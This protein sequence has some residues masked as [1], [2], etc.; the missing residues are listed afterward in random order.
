M[1]KQI[2]NTVV[3]RVTRSGADGQGAVYEK[4]RAAALDTL[5]K[6]LLLERSRADVVIWLRGQRRDV[7]IHGDAATDLVAGEAR[8]PL[9]LLAPL[10]REM[11]I[12]G[13]TEIVD[14]RM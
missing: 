2:L 13:H 7:T 6:S 11:L 12:Q 10:V 5:R 4:P 14:V 9:L 3:P 8:L 1:T